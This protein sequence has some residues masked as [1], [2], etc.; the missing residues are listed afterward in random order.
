[1]PIHSFLFDFASFFP[2][3]NRNIELL[4]IDLKRIEALA[5]SHDH[6]DHQAALVSCLKLKERGGSPG[7]S[8]YVG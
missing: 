7:N 3:V 1:M 4:K 2:G 8:F 6:L 5:L